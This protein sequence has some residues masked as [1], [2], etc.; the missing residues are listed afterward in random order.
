MGNV[1]SIDL[2]SQKF[3]VFVNL[4]LKLNCPEIGVE[5]IY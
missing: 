2:L 4:S 1:W 3:P 5:A